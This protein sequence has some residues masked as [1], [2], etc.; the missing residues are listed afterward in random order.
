MVLLTTYGAVGLGTSGCVQ[1]RRAEPRRWAAESAEIAAESRG[2]REVGF[3]RCVLI[4]PPGM[5]ALGGSE[6]S[7]CTGF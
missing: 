5:C 1:G 2:T 6:A 3:S 4:H 7:S